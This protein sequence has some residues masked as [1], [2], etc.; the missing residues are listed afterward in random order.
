MKFIYIVLFV[1]FFVTVSFSQITRENSKK[2]TT[3]ATFLSIGQGARAIGMGSAFVAI[4]NDPSALYW[5]PAGITKVSGVGFVVDHTNWFADINYNF[6]AL[7]Y[8][9]GD[10]G[11]FGASLTI[12][13]IGEMKVTT[14]ESPEGTGQVFGV[15][16]AA[17]SLAWAINLTDNFSIG[18]NPKF[19]HQSIWTMSAST[20]AL[21]LGVQYVTPFDGAILAMSISNFGPKMR[22]QG[23]AAQTLFDPNLVST[24]NNGAIPVEYLTEEW[25]LP[26]I[27]RVG[28]GYQPVHL[29]E[30]ILTLTADA[31]HLNDNYESVNIGAEYAFDD[32]LFIRGG[33]KSL[34]LDESEESL[35]LGFGIKQLVVGS[36]AIKVDYAYQDFG[37]LNSIQKFT[38]GISF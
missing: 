35:A 10:F 7:T 26:L 3:A 31:L 13:D 20:F 18:F 4:T 23:E 24:G 33:Y 22:M 29:D 27:F 17:F 38:V 16:D 37:R 21:D 25:D 11:T 36:I 34:F 1:M 8:N 19:V 5:N 15:T 32:F 14:L 28:L 9:L 12:S 30:H 6:L 2:G